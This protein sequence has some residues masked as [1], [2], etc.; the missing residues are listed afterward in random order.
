MQPMYVEVDGRMS[1]LPCVSAQLVNYNGASDTIECVKS[2]FDS[3]H[4]NIS[5]LVIDNASSKTDQRRLEDELGSH[6]HL[7]MN[8]RNLGFAQ[9]HNLGIRYTRR[10]TKP[11]YHLILNNDVVVTHGFLSP[12]IQALESSDRIGISGPKIK[13]LNTNILDSAGSIFNNIGSAYSRGNGEEDLG[14]YDGFEIVPMITSCCMLVKDEVFDRTYPFDDKFFMYLEEL[15][16]N[17]R[18]WNRGFLPAYVPSSVVYH[19][20]SSSVKRTTANPVLFKQTLEEGNRTRILL[21]HFPPQSLLRNSHLILLS[22]L[23][24]QY[25]TLRI[26]GFDWFKRLNLNIISGMRDGL[27][28]R[29]EEREYILASWLPQV[30]HMRLEN[31][32]VKAGLMEKKHG[33]KG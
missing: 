19:R 27:K 15:D 3:G 10:C 24:W 31:Y 2:L 29:R 1:D 8:D 5:V 13:L 16:F 17:M 26:G 9:A 21:K 25:N 33:W 11:K 32:I 18:L 4:S 22:Y 20:F 14:Q 23:Y 30:E 12:L 28:S 6:V 7:I